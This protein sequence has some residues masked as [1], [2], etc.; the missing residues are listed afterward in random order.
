MNDYFSKG[1]VLCTLSRKNFKAPEI[2]SLPVLK[3]LLSKRLNLQIDNEHHTSTVSS[4]SASLRHLSINLPHFLRCSCQCYSNK[5]SHS[6][7]R[8]VTQIQYLT[9]HLQAHSIQGAAAIA[10]AVLLHSWEVSVPVQPFTSS[11]HE[12]LCNNYRRRGEGLL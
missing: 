4:L 9:A 7:V 3:K 11:E 6:Y 2:T 12:G 10:A 1:V 8:R 5:V